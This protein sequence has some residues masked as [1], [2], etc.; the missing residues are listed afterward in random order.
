[1]MI[2]GLNDLLV[3]VV[4]GGQHRRSAADPGYASLD[5]GHVFRSIVSVLLVVRLISFK[6]LLGFRRQRRHSSVLGV[7]DD[8]STP[9]WQGPLGVFLK[10]RIVVPYLTRPLGRLAIRG[11]GSLT[12]ISFQDPGFVVG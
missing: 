9:V 2:V 12:R 5:G 3:V 10:H 1:Q 11:L 4:E 6:F 7:C 8:G